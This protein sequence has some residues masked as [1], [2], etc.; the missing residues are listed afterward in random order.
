MFSYK[1][2]HFWNVFQ[3]REGGIGGAER[4]NQMASLSTHAGGGLELSVQNEVLIIEKNTRC[5]YKTHL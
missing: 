2:H 4:D 1:H 3:G 5:D